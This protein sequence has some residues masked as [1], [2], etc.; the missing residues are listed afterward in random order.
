MTRHRTILIRDT[1]VDYFD[2][3]EDIVK[4]EEMDY[5][6]HGQYKDVQS[7]TLGDINGPEYIVIFYVPRKE[8]EQ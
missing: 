2:F 7:V 3:G 8:A 4:A 6:I 5:E 1:G